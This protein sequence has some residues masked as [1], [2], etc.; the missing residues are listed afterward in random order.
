[1][2]LTEKEVT[3]GSLAYQNTQVKHWNTDATVLAEFLEEYPDAT[4]I[5][6]VPFLDKDGNVQLAHFPYDVDGVICGPPIN[7][8][9]PCPPFC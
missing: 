9:H 1:M 2:K 7:N 8:S 5:R 4:V 3:K 6:H